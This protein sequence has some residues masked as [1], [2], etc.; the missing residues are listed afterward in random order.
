M[1]VFAIKKM[2]KVGNKFSPF[3]DY[4]MVKYRLVKMSLEICC[5]VTLLTLKQTKGII[6]KYSIW[7]SCEKSWKA[8]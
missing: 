8:I 3:Y 7:K 2:F 1:V 5:T 4:I 6:L